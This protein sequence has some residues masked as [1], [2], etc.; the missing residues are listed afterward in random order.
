MKHKNIKTRTY[1]TES[2]YICH[3]Q[4]AVI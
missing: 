4:Y 2:Q 3:S 1:N